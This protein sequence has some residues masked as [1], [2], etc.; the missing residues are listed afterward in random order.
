MFFWKYNPAKKISAN[1]IKFLRIPF[2]KI[3]QDLRFKGKFFV[4]IDN[5]RLYLFHH[6][7][8]N[9]ENEIFWKGIN[10][11]WEKETIKLWRKLSI[12]ADYIID[13]G[14]NTGIYSLLSKL[15]NPESKVYSFEPSKNTFEKL[16]QNF[17]I[18]NFSDENLFDLAISNKDGKATFFDY[19][20][21]H[22]YSASLE[23]E[24]SKFNK[25]VAKKNYIVHTI[26]LDSFIEQHNIKKID[27]ELH[28]YKVLEGMG[29]YFESFRPIIIIEILNNSIGARIEEFVTP[30]NYDFYIISDKEGLIKSANII[31]SDYPNWIL[32]PNKTKANNEK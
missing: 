19:D 11:G 28:E 3:Y 6:F 8:T 31:C 9:I 12:N 7:H 24:M 23:E 17:L 20:I 4:K 32:M 22:Q 15:T 27:V 10:N 18:N 13:I 2:H 14:A 5:K 25:D 29:K 1:I 16:K 30:H 26:R 21:D